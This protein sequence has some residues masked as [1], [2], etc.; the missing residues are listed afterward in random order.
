[1]KECYLCGREFGDYATKYIASDGRVACFW[2][3]SYKPRSDGKPGCGEN[4][5]AELPPPGP[6]F[7]VYSDG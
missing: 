5:K 7:H 3:A 2:P 6:E 4:S 1:M